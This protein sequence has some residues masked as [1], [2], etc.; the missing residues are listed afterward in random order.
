MQI[1]RETPEMGQVAV[2]GQ[3]RREGYR[4]SPSGVRYIWQKHDLETTVKRLRAL[5]SQAQDGEQVLTEKQ[6]QLLARGNLSAS[7]AEDASGPKDEPLDRR[8]VILNVAAELFSERGYA[9]TSIRDIANHAGLLP[10]SVYHHFPSKEDLYLEIH[11]EGFRRVMSRVTTAAA[12]GS[13]PWDSLRRACQVHVYGMLAGSPVDRITGHSLSLTGHQELFEK[14]KS[15]RAAYEK[16]FRSLVDAL[17]LAPEVDRS[18]LRLTLLG[19]LNWVVIWYREGRQSPEAIADAM[20]AMLRTGVENSG[21][22][23]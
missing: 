12:Q 16:L 2:A 3:L 19:A 22:E 7:L 1:A 14:V 15:D 10:G 13:D 11:R 18:L 8:R 17:P 5:A 9:Q 20:V 21:S 4:I 23:P 6:Q